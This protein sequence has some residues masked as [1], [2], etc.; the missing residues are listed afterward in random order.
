M[1]FGSNPSY[2][3]LKY[4]WWNCTSNI[5]MQ[6]KRQLLQHNSLQGGVLYANHSL[7]ITVLSYCWASDHLSA[8]LETIMSQQTADGYLSLL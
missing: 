3:E 6:K 7:F 4:W 5:L 2:T 1:D 8:L